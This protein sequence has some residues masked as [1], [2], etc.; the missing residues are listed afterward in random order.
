ME[1]INVKPKNGLIVRDPDSL[2]PLP[3]EGHAVPRN[4]Y[5][6]RRVE[7]GDVEL[8]EV[9]KDSPTQSEQLVAQSIKANRRTTNE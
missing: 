6:L 5:W 1:Q 4:D 3:P 2:S 8:V 7:Q 9:I